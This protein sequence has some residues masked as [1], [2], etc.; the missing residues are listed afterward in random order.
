M[1]FAKTGKV[2]HQGRNASAVLRGQYAL[3]VAGALRDELRETHH[4]IKTIV[5]WTGANE[6]TVKNWLAG[7]SGPSGEHL[8]AL[9]RNSDEIFETL[10]LLTGR[11]RP[12]QLTTTTLEDLRER[13]RQALAMA[14]AIVLPTNN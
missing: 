11:E 6:R 5:K 8:I 13:L 12:H 9:V 3:V 10:L 1:S 4:A 2:F 14:E 7:T